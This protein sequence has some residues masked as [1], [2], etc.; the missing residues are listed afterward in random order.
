MGL[1]RRIRGRSMDGKSHPDNI[2]DKTEQCE[3][4]PLQVDEFK[5]E[6]YKLLR[7]L[8]K[9][10]VDSEFTGLM[11]LQININTFIPALLKMGLIRIGTCK[12]ALETLKL[13]SLRE[14]LKTNG[15]RTGGKKEELINRIVSDIDEPNIKLS[16]RYHD[17]YVH[18]SEGM[19]AIE[20]SYAKCSDREISFLKQVVSLISEGDLYNAYKEVCDRNMRES[21][22]RGIGVDWSKERINGLDDGLRKLFIDELEKHSYGI[23]ASLS[24]F[25][26][27]SGESICNVVKLAL[28]AFPAENIDAEEIRYMSSCLSSLREIKECLFCGDEDVVFIASLDEMT[29]PICGNLDGK[30]ININSGRIGID[31]PPMHKGCRCT[32]AGID[33]IRGLK[34]IG[35]RSRNPITNKNEVIPYMTYNQWKNKYM[36]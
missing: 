20:E 1:W 10:P 32:I 17:V 18:T 35:R 34:S 21:I 8:N 15:I 27:L 4:I 5:E 9:H 19:R 25:T 7:R 13:D 28:K 26:E 14:I 29:C 24:I 22:P 12:E 11:S 30:K 31:L 2:N 6:H 36:N 16:E 33:D 3:S 23:N